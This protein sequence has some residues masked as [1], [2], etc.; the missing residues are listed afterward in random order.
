MPEYGPYLRA[1]G[2]KKRLRLAGYELNSYII[3]HEEVE[4]YKQYTYDTFLNFIAINDYNEKILVKKLKDQT[5][6]SRI[7]ITRFG[8]PYRCWF[9]NPKIIKHNKDFSQVIILCKGY[10]KRVYTFK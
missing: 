3:T 2:I 6:K 5:K 10:A 7:V 1:F 8:N 9:D 4:M